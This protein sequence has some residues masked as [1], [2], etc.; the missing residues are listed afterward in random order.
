MHLTYQASITN[1]DTESLLSLDLFN[2]M[3][4]MLERR[5]YVDLIVNKGNVNVLK[6]TYIQEYGI[7]GRHFNSIK[8]S[9]EG[10]VSALLALNKIALSDIRVKLQKVTTQAD[11]AKNQLN[12]FKT[13]CVGLKLTTALK[14]TRKT[15]VHAYTNAQQRLQHTQTKL[16]QLELIAQSKTP[17]IC[18]GSK[19]LFNQQHTQDHEAW[20]KQWDLSRNHTFMLVGSSDE[21]KSNQNCQLT[22]LKDNTFEVRVNV[23]PTE[24]SPAL[25]YVTF[26]VTIHSGCSAILQALHQGQAL[27]YRFYLQDNGSYKLLISLD[28]SVQAPKKV[29]SIQHG[30]IG[31]D[32]NAAHLSVSDI[33]RH[34]NLQKIFDIPMD[35]QGTSNDVTTNIIALS[36]KEL[37][38]Y[39]KE[40]GKAIVIEDLDFEEKRKAL[41]S[42]FNTQYNKMLSGFAYAKITQLIQARGLDAGIEVRTVNPMFT[43]VIGHYKYQNRYKMTSHQAAAFVIARRGLFS[44]P[45]HMYRENYISPELQK[46]YA[47]KLPVRK[48]CKGVFGFWRKMTQLDPQSKKKKQRACALRFNPVDDANVIRM[49][50]SLF[51]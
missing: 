23:R 43:S 7:N 33:D 9:I 31:V 15:L 22:H 46:H 30:I 17:P 42:G 1:E 24:T 48:T 40:K 28:K 44:T 13:H 32:I 34:G 14:N 29:S 20:F 37:I 50:N 38:S 49:V 27:S 11:A 8:D 26:N 16:K 39:A 5:L 36:V 21:P 19:N 10:K 2:R 25:R 51:V 41:K 12:A 6:T 45:G 18:F 3:F 47:F 4:N 35:Y